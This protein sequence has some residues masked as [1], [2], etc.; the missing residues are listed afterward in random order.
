MALKRVKLPWWHAPKLVFVLAVLVAIVSVSASADVVNF[1]DPGLE[2][3]IRE[4]IGIPTGDIQDSDLTGVTHLSASERGISELEGIQYCVNLVYLDLWDNRIDDIS[5]LST[6]TTLEYLDL[7]DNQIDDISALSTLTTLEY[8]DL[9]GNQ[10]VIIPD[11]SDLTVLEELYLDGN[12]VI[13]ISALSDL[14]S[15][16]R[17]SL[18]DNQIVDISP[19]SGLTDLV[20]LYL[21][22]NQIFDISALVDAA[23]LG[24]LN[25]LY[26]RYN[27]LQVTLGS[28]DRQDIQAL[29]DRGVT[30]YFEPQNAFCSAIGG[31]INGDGVVGLVDVRLCLQIA[32]GVLTGT[33]QQRQAA[34]VDGDGDVDMDDVKILSEYAIGIRPTL[35]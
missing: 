2:A 19:L 28:D 20:Y 4:E 26:I 10:I 21:Q 6:L 31:D 11:L 34:D 35:P 5:A 13:D 33:P 23:G 25:R 27:C 8:L 16:R 22:G 18:D 17:L 12:Q 14:T 7:W 3:A 29:I 30:V 15:L 24:A 32:D 1:P 9:E